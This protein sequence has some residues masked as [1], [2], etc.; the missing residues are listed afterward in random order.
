MKRVSTIDPATY[1][2]LSARV[3]KCVSL[4]QSGLIALFVC[5][6]MS[7]GVAAKERDLPALCE[8]AAQTVALSSGV[9]ASVLRTITL[10]ESGRKHGKHLR[11]WPWT[12]NME[13]VG[14]WFATQAE[15]RAYVQTHFDGGA[16]SFDVGCFQINYRWH[17]QAFSSIDE[18]FDPMANARY[19][20]S[21]LKSLHAELGD[22]SLAAGAYH[23]RTPKYAL[24]YRTRFDQLRAT[25]EGVA[26]PPVTNTVQAPPPSP[27]ESPLQRA[28]SFPLLQAD[29]ALG[30]LGSLVPIAGRVAHQQFLVLR[31]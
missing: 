16:R 6:I 10:T 7:H 20:A 26:P 9:P 22:W 29:A 24:R 28:N 2:R 30:Q 23:S 17:G 12:V 19:A 14:K 1:A 13:G 4:F 5:L 15:A 8:S 21:F 31:Q 27:P 25:L 11:P 3:C 18:M